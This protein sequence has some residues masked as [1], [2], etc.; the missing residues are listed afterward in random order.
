MVVFDL[1]DFEIIF[2]KF[3]PFVVFFSVQK[4]DRFLTWENKDRNIFLSHC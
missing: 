1:F 4:Y 2:E 3:T